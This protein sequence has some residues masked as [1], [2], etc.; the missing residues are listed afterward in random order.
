[1]ATLITQA[2]DPTLWAA[3]E[4]LRS[5]DQWIRY[6]MHHYRPVMLSSGAWGFNQYTERELMDDSSLDTSAGGSYSELDG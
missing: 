5:G 2:S 4:A 1:M 3:L 6:E